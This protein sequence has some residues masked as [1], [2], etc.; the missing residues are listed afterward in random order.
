MICVKGCLCQVE[1][2][3]RSTLHPRLCFFS[4]GVVKPI[5]RI[6]EYCF[7]SDD[8]TYVELW[9]SQSHVW[10]RGHPHAKPF[11]HTSRAKPVIP[12]KANLPTEHPPKSELSKELQP[13]RLRHSSFYTIFICNPHHLS[14]TVW[15]HVGP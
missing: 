7:G 2:I 6:A 4:F 1:I 14:L 10:I 11:P 9:S 13:I 8:M 5:E 3:Q 15:V 12:R